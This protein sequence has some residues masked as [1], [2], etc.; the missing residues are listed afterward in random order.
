MTATTTFIAA[1]ALGLLAFRPALGAEGA[2]PLARIAAIARA[3]AVASTGRPAAEIEVAPLDSRLRL[4]ACEAAPVGRLTPGTRSA[5]QLTIEVH[6]AAP[7]WRQFVAVRVNALE[8]VVIAARPL[9]RL[10]VVTAEDLAVLPRELASLPAGYFRTAEEVLGHIAQRNVGAGEAL[11]P[12]AV[13]AP[14]LVRRGQS[15]TL[16]VRDGG[17]Y[18]RATG[19]VL[20][21]AGLAERVRVRNVS[22]SRLVEGV[23]RSADT[24]EVSLE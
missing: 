12:G 23:V 17:L 15:V 19:V 7:A 13:R 2:E 9:A 14:P 6:C 18:V 20:A 1:C 5:A 24:V 22:S 21:D 4:P 16:L 11:S 10:Q 8:R 3:T